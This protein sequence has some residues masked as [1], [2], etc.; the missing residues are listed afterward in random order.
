MTSI[1][2]HLYLATI[3]LLVLTTPLFVSSCGEDPIAPIDS[4]PVHMQAATTSLIARPKIY[5]PEND[6]WLEI[7]SSQSRLWNDSAFLV[8]GKLDSIDL[9]FML[10]SDSDWHF[11]SDPSKRY[12]YAKEG[13]RYIFRTDDTNT[14]FWATKTDT[15]YMF[16]MAFFIFVPG[17]VYAHHSFDPDLNIMTEWGR[18]GADTTAYKTY[19]LHFEPKE[20]LER[21]LR[22]EEERKRK[23][24]E[25]KENGD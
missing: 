15:A 12:K 20:E 5:V 17:E 11:V 7:S 14:V 1:P 25:E 24:E 21:K 16:H 2:R 3:C 8:I 23:E 13:D 19:Q 22:E 18:E 6:G 4:Y 10:L 9:D